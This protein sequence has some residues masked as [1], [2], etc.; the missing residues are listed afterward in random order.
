LSDLLSPATFARMKQEVPSIQQVTIP[1]RGHASMLDE[2]EA[3]GA[4]DTFLAS[5]PISDRSNN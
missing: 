1:R 4:V 2:P 5:L 3:L